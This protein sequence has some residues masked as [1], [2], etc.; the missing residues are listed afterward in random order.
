M[1]KVTD[2]R[3]FWDRNALHE[4]PLI[5]ND[6]PTI[7]VATYRR[8]CVA[9]S[10]LLRLE[11]SDNVL[12]I[13]C[14]A[15]QFEAFVQNRVRS[16][17]AFDFSSNMIQ[18]A[19][20]LNPNHQQAFFVQ[21]DCTQLPFAD[22]TFSKLLVFSV[23]HYL[24]RHQL[25]EMLNEALRVLEPGGLFLIGDIREASLGHMRFAKKLTHIYRQEGLKFYSSAPV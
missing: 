8:M 5:A 21:G 11:Q 2:W 17:V 16:I 24:N 22:D 4:N 9:V 23:T 14:G 25:R 18:K 19:K 13:G 12:N 15:G 10:R 1:T 7:G 20:S 6:F 3:D